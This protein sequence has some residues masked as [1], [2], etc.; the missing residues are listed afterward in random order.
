M[1][2]LVLQRIEDIRNRNDNFKK[3]LQRWQNMTIAVGMARTEYPI[4]DVDFKELDDND[5]L[6]ALE[7]IIRRTSVMM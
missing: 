3:S 5:L 4:Q 2:E 7:R 6:V 1:R